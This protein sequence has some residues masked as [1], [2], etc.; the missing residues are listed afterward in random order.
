MEILP[1]P[2]DGYSIDSRWEVNALM[3]CKWM[4]FSR[5]YPQRLPILC[6]FKGRFAESIV[7]QHG[8]FNVIHDSAGR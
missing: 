5:T 8:E 1:R 6:G 7:F 3:V 4:A 2:L